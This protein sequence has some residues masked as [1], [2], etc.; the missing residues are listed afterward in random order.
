MRISSISKVT[1]VNKAMTVTN[2]ISLCSTN[3]IV[4]PKFVPIDPAKIFH[5]NT[6]RICLGNRPT[7]VTVEDLCYDNFYRK[8]VSKQHSTESAN[9]ARAPVKTTLCENAGEPFIKQSTC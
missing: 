2:D 7:P 8:F 1:R 6:P 3:L 5:I 4:F 9:V